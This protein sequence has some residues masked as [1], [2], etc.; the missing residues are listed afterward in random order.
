MARCQH[1]KTFPQQ[2]KNQTSTP[3]EL[4]HS[5][6]VGPLL[7][8][9]LNGSKFFM[10]FIYEFLNWIYFMSSKAKTFIKFKFLKQLIEGGKKWKIKT[11]RFDHGGEFTSKEI[12]NYCIKNG[13]K[14]QLT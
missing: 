1:K 14:R 5:N 11:L 10:V 4:I 3:S 9:S 7:T 13:I 12:N 8:P 6:L 2:F